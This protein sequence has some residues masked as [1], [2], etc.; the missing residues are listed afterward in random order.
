[1]PLTIRPRQKMKN[2]S[3]TNSIGRLPG[4]CGVFVVSLALAYFALSP[5]RAVLPAPDGGYPGN[6]T[7]EG[8]DALFSLTTGTDNTAL[9]FNALFNNTTATD[10]TATGSHALLSNTTGFGNT[11]N[12]SY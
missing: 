4:R 12:G 10:N 11:A 1:M 2:L 5:A 8:T 9:G 6:N 3:I 7:A